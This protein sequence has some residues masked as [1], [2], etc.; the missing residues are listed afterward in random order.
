MTLTYTPTTGNFLVAAVY[1]RRDSTV[2]SVTLPTGFTQVTSRNTPNG[3]G[4]LVIGYKENVS[5]SVTSYAF[6]RT[7]KGDPASI[8]AVMYEY[9][10]IKTLLSSDQSAFNSG[11]GTSA[12]TG[13][14][15]TT[16]QACE[17]LIGAVGSDNVSDTYSSPPNS[18]AI[19]DQQA[20]GTNKGNVGLLERIVNATGAYST[21][22][23]ISASSSWA[24]LIVTF[25]GM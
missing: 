2:P 3:Q 17:L 8:S 10:G 9:S 13:T 11:T 25:K 12:S 5:S 14:T 22:A 6:A 21:G 24:G 16:G 23:T 7:S 15:G 19:V 4:R 18:F 1:A 20:N